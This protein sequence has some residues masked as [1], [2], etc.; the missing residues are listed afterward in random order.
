MRSRI[1]TKGYGE[2]VRKVPRKF[3]M[4]CYFQSSG[5]LFVEATYGKDTVSIEALNNVLNDKAEI[6][7]LVQ[8]RNIENWVIKFTRRLGFIEQDDLIKTWW[9]GN[10]VN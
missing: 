9:E 8:F 1:H 4:S 5:V 6:H 2:G 3:V 10:L 7:L